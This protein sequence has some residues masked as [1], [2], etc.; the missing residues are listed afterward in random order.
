M[1]AAVLVGKRQIRFEDRPIPQP[2]V[3]EVQIKVAKVGICG[4]DVHYYTEGRIGDFVVKEPIVLGHEF[5]GTVSRV[6][7][8]VS[9]VKEGDRVV[10]EPGFP[11][12]LC[13]VCLSGRYNVC[14]R[15]DFF[16]SPP[17]DGAFREYVLA[18][19]RFI[20]PISDDTSFEE[21]AFA[22]PTAVAVHSVNRGSVHL[23]DSALVIGA[24]P[25]GLLTLQVAFSAGAS[26]VYV[27]DMD[28]ARLDVAG[29]LGATKIIDASKGTVEQVMKI[30][31]GRGVDVC[32]EAVGKEATL[33]E[34]V[35]AAGPGGRVVAIGLSPETTL[36]F[37]FFEFMKKE[38]DIYGVWRYRWAYPAAIALLGSKR[39]KVD[40][41]VT[42]RFG[43]DDLEE[44]LLT[45][46]E[47]RGNPIKV[48]VSVES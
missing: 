6:G 1:K 38:L 12:G 27:S 25:I 43:L 34:A 41:L 30:T 9:R 14:P 45:C 22:E 26:A 17:I 16:G 15:V 4:S 37:H 23:G 46:A 40:R 20:F 10:V 24:G 31:G 3:K 5:S 36:P 32:L 29:E 39:V 47:M 35:D 42:H 18:P 7:E 48:V 2:K 13:D 21:G 8:D 19:E 11:C 44:A 28:R 33:N